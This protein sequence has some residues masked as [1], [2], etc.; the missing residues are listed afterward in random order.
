MPTNLVLIEPLGYVDMIALIANARGVLTDS[1]GI[2]KESFI[3][4]TRCA[5]LR[6]NTE[7]PDTFIEGRNR[8]V[9]LNE[10]TIVKALAEPA[11][12][13]LPRSHPFGPIGAS[14]RTVQAIEAFD[15]RSMWLER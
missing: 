15:D 10:E 3:L 7:W 4:G 2:Q 11:I 8:L 5:T 9:G 14:A 12:E 13:G 6:E 1:G